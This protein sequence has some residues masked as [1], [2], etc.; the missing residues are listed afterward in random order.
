MSMR[1]FS[2]A[3]SGGLMLALP[4]A[5][6]AQ[7]HDVSPYSMG[8][9]VYT[10]GA[11]HDGTVY[12]GERVFGYDFGELP[13]GV[14]EALDPGFFFPESY[15]TDFNS[16]DMPNGLS[17]AFNVLSP[18]QVWN[19]SS[20]DVVSNG[21]FINLETGLDGPVSVT[22]VSGFQAGFN[23]L[24]FLR[25]GN[26]EDAHISS[27][28]FDSTV[29]PPVPTGVY[30]VELQITAP[31]RIASDPIFVVYNYG[32][33]EVVHDEA[34]EFVQSAIPE[35]ASLGLLAMALPFVGRRRR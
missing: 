13:A 26:D 22:G 23:V 6:R 31:G 17:F 8:G 32:E 28:L 16:T 4:V 14:N 1:N 34:I 24:T 21:D 11:T 20:F 10:N 5:V 18:L 15:E 33:T 25:D 2:L 30:L 9:R 19:G 3:L 27:T 12:P 35:P 29:S 7:H